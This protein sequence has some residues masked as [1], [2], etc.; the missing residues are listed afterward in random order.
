VNNNLL[1]AILSMD[2]Y[3]RGSDP[4]LVVDANSI[5]GAT[6]GL[7]RED[8]FTSFFAQAYDL[9]GQKIISY[10]GTVNAALD[11]LSAYSTAAGS[12]TSAQALE[13]VQFYQDVVGGGSSP[14]LGQLD[15]ANVWLTGHSLGGGLAGLIASVYGQHAAIF[16][17]MAFSLAA[18]KLYLET[19]THANPADSALGELA[20]Y[21]GGQPNPIN[22]VRNR[23]LPAG[24]TDSAERRGSAG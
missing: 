18:S 24:G 9:G 7:S 20:Y 16:D 6:V 3:N 21:L 23:V 12:Y 15:S 13:A 14:T 5:G 11:V 4:G 1:L 17:S 8:N 22:A 10:R 2:A 19:T